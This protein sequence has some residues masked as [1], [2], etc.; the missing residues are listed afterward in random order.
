MHAA[1]AIASHRGDEFGAVPDG[2]VQ[3]VELSGQKHHDRK[4]RRRSGVFRQRA[5][6]PRDAFG[7]AREILRAH[8]EQNVDVRIQVTSGSAGIVGLHVPTIPRQRT[9]SW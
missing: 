2:G 7:P 9:G 6:A 3:L 8:R 4:L 5:A 1:D